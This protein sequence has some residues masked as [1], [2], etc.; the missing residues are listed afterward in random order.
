[1]GLRKLI[2]ETLE[3]QLN[4]SLILK[5]D[6]EISNAL[7]YHID[8]G[9]TL[10]ENAFMFYSEGYFNLINE[11]RDLWK[12][13]KIELNQNDILMVESDLGIKV[14][15]GKEYVYL[16]APYIYESE[17]DIL[18]EGKTSERPKKFAVYTKSKTEGI[19]KITFGNSNLILKESR[20][21]SQKTDRTTAGYWSCNVGRYTKQLGLSS[22]NSW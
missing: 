18:S 19:K 1:M 2:K 21:C 11:V 7:Q 17:E 13:G 4:K 6:I 9:M 16:D 8:N 5:E 12:E 15:I 14:K 22:S 10:T 20:N 3:Q